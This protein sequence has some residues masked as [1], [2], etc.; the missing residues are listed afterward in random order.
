VVGSGCRVAR[1]DD[2]E[3]EILFACLILPLSCPRPIGLKCHLFFVRCKIRSDDAKVNVAW[4]GRAGCTVAVCIRLGPEF[5]LVRHLSTTLLFGCN[6]NRSGEA[7]E[8][9]CRVMIVT[10]PSTI[11][12]KAVFPKCCLCI[13]PN[14]IYHGIIEPR[15]HVRTYK[16]S[17]CP[18]YVGTWG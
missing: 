5:L 15:C 14:A 10:S 1:Y 16:R 13:E 11:P 6:L 17:L 18:W 8:V 9:R 12:H 3:R 4:H 2:L 7:M